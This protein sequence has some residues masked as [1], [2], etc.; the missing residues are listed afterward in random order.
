[1]MKTKINET[2]I[3]KLARSYYDYNLN[4]YELLKLKLFNPAIILKSYD[5]TPKTYFILCCFHNLNYI[6]QLIDEGYVSDKVLFESISL[7]LFGIK[8]KPYK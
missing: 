4:N 6:L 7:D 8:S 1:M 5:N 3:K 2:S